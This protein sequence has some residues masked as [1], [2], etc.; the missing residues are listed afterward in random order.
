MSVQGPLGKPDLAVRVR[1]MAFQTPFPRPDI[2]PQMNQP[3]AP[4][5]VLAGFRKSIDNID[6]ALIHMLA[7]RFRITQAVGQYKA[8]T[9]LPASDAGREAQQIARLRALAVEAELD[10]EFSEKFIRFVIDEV[11]RHHRQQAEGK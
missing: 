3:D 8:E 5:P 9:G 2:A 6:A 7:E 10:P 4:D 11:I 1:P